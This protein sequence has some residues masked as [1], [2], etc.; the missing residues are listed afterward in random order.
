MFDNASIYKTK[1]VRLLVKKLE[2]V[3]FTILP[4]SLELNQIEHTVG[5]LKSKMSKKNY[6]ANSKG[7]DK[8]FV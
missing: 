3:V 4:Y 1:E 8:V 7:I 2:W 5:I 6:N